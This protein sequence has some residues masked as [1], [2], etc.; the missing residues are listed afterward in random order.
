[1]GSDISCDCFAGVLPDGSDDAMKERLLQLQKGEKF[2]RSALLGLTSKEL[3]VKLSDDTS[4]IEWRATSKSVWE[5]G[6]SSEEFGEVD[7]TTE[8]KSVKMSGKQGLQFISNAD[9]SKCLLEIQ[10]QDPSTRD[11]WVLALNE[12]LQTWND[13][14]DKKPKPS[15]S[16]GGTSNKAEYFKKRQEEIEARE[17]EAKEKKQKFASNG[18]KYTAIAMANRAS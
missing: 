7:L 11:Q 5:I 4:K 9:D 18:M 8:V 16:A 15:V 13:H 3:N 12:L 14:P 2:M 17:K 6:S 10:A 1:M